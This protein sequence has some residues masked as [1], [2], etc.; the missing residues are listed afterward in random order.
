MKINLE[1]QAV[2]EAALGIMQLDMQ[3]IPQA[4]S[5]LIILHHLLNVR[6]KILN[7]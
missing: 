7:Y 3:T 2:I 4:H 1:I 5:N 6:R